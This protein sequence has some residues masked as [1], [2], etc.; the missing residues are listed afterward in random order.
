LPALPK[1]VTNSSFVG[2]FHIKPVDPDRIYFLS[3]EREF[4][5]HVN[6]VEAAQ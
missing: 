6:C 3:T 5:P 1:N 2:H 4:T